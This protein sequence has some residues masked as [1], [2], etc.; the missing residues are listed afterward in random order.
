[1]W[2]DEAKRKGQK[3]GNLKYLLCHHKPELGVRVPTKVT[4]FKAPGTKYQPIER[5]QFM[6][7]VVPYSGKNQE[8]KEKWGK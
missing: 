6:F 7:G 2:Q 5:I 1:M 4:V 3:V 8:K